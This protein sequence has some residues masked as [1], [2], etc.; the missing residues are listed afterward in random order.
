MRHHERLSIHQ[1]EETRVSREQ[2][3]EDVWAE[4]MTTVALKYEVSSS[5]LARI[6]TRLN[7][8]RP[9]RGYWAMYATG[10]RPKQPPLPEARPGDELEWARHGGYARVAQ[11]PPPQVPQDGSM[12][13]RRRGLPQLHP[14]LE[15][16]KEYIANA[17]ESRYGFLKPKKYLLPDLIASKE[18]LD[19]AIYVANDLYLSFEKRGHFCHDSAVWTKHAPPCRR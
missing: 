4:P 16:F 17:G 6:C 13:R 15:G 14:L 2:L 11:L 8:P 10:K 3:Y 18:M 19:R 7:V 1:K 9:Q 5:F 12:K